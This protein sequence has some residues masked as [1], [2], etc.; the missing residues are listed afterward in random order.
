[1]SEFQSKDPNRPA[2]DGALNASAAG[3]DPLYL[4]RR[5]RWILRAPPLWRC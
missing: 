4:T 5:R 2:Q 3:G 1:M